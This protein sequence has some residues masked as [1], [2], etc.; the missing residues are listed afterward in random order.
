M[1]TSHNIDSNMYLLRQC[2]IDMPFCCIH[3]VD[4]GAQGHLEIV[5]ADTAVARMTRDSPG[6]ASCIL[7]ARMAVRRQA[8]EV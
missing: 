1:M 8:Q 6:R 5:H 4:D 7:I 3:R 2:T